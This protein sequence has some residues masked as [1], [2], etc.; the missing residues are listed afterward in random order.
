MDLNLSTVLALLTAFLAGGV[1]FLK[2]LAPL[3]KTKVDDKLLEAGEKG[4]EVAK[5]VS[6]IV[7]AATK[8]ATQPITRDHRK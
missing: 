6:P 7:G 4:L 8:V 3:T 2:V 5:V 1:T